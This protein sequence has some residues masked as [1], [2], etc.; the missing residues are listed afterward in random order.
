MPIEPA[1]T[2]P[3]I[4]QRRLRRPRP[5]LPALPRLADGFSLPDLL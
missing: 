3:S 1:L 4:W 2:L 5:L